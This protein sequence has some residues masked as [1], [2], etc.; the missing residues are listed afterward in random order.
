MKISRVF[1]AIW[2]WRFGFG[3][4]I[5]WQLWLPSFWTII[6]IGL[7]WPKVTWIFRLNGFVW[8][9]KRDFKVFF[10]L[11]LEIFFYFPFFVL[12]S[13]RAVVTD[14]LSFSDIDDRTSL[15]NG[16]SRL[17][18]NCIDARI[19]SLGVL[20]IGTAFTVGVY[21]LQQGA[22]IFSILFLL[23]QGAY[24]NA[25]ISFLHI[26]YGLWLFL[27]TFLE[28]SIFRPSNVVDK[29]GFGESR[30]LGSR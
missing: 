8:H 18:S 27:L 16:T 7:Y 15:L 12:L 5:L 28:N 25:F 30:G 21:I 13:D 4:W 23:W 11:K 14:R 19:F 20:F 3:T 10:L 6:K 22:F 1:I 17:R 9:T 2:I 26:S 24:L 29:T